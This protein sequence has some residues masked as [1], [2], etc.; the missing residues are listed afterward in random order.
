MPS[1]PCINVTWVEV[2]PN[3][4]NLVGMTVLAGSVD[5]DVSPVLAEK[6]RS[7]RPDVA[8]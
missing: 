8:Y 1:Y 3:E 5:R 7:C 4:S 2:S 6:F